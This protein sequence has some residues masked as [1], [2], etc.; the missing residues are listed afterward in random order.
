[1]QLPS[2]VPYDLTDLRTVFGAAIKAGGGELSETYPS[3]GSGSSCRRRS[4][5]SKLLVK[6]FAA[7]FQ[8]APCNAFAP[9]T[10]IYKQGAV[11]SAVNAPSGM[12]VEFMRVAD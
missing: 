6:C 7:P 1:M 9:S 8:C 12:S 5:S 10:N 11:E 2:P 4:S 3:S